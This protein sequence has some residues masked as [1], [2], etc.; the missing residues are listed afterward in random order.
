LT[1]R[2]LIRGRSATAWSWPFTSI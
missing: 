1:F 2:I